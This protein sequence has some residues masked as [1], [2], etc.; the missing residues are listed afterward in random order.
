MLT[1]A[2]VGFSNVVIISFCYR[3]Y[4]NFYNYFLYFTPKKF[5]SDTN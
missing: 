5:V 4:N 3:H 1:W 2:L